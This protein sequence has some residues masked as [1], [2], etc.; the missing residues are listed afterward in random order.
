MYYANSFLSFSDGVSAHFKNNTNILNLIHH[1]A[2]FNLE[3]SWTFT[4]ACHGKGAGDG[5]GAVV[6]T[7]ARRAA[8]SK[9]YSPINC[10]R[11]L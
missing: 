9:E 2:D 8:L 11:L 5:I 7:I 6:K 4:A 1:K 3:A 10:E